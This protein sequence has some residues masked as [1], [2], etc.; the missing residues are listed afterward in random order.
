MVRLWVAF[1]HDLDHSFD[2][3]ER[4]LWQLDSATSMMWNN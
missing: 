2:I 3:G 4:H 1:G